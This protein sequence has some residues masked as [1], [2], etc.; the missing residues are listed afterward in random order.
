MFGNMDGSICCVENF[1]PGIKVNRK[2]KT[3]EQTKLGFLY[4]S[5]KRY[6]SS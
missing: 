3:P 5:I 2:K 1:A 4:I 6:K